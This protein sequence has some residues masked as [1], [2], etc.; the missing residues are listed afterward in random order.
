[1]MPL[2]TTEN[3]QVGSDLGKQLAVGASE[4]TLAGSTYE[5]GNSGEKGVHG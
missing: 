5:G 2:W 4:A 3:C 1:M